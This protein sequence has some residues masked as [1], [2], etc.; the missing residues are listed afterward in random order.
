MRPEPSTEAEVSTIPL[1]DFCLLEGQLVEAEYDGRT[2]SGPWAFMCSQH[3]QSN[4]AGLG[5]GKGQ[6]IILGKA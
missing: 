3:F 1:C 6:R 5:L 4:G 2:K